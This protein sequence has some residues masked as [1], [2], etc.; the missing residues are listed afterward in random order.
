[1]VEQFDTEMKHWEGREEEGLVPVR[2]RGLLRRVN[3]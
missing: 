3:L 1:M 2:R